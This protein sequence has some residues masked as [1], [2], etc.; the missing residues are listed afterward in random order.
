MQD[1]AEPKR[2][3]P[4]WDRGGLPAWTYFSRELLEIEEELLFRRHWQL[5]CHVA[6]LPEP[7]DFQTLDI[8]GERAL[9]VRGRDGAIRAFHNLCR[10]RGSRVVAEEQG[11]LRNVIICP[12]HGWTYDLEGRLRWV[13]QPRALPP[14]DADEWGLKALA[15]ISKEATQ[16]EGQLGT[17]KFLAKAPEEVVAEQRDRLETARA[18]RARLEAARARLEE[19]G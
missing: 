5:V 17:E 7:G 1:P 13:A 10:H 15:K 18:E 12:F 11:N 9:I 14:L 4:D 16:L 19:I 2:V 3:P 8:A 6:D